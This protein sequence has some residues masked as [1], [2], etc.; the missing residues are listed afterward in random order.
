MSAIPGNGALDEVKTLMSQMDGARVLIAD[1]ERYIRAFLKILISKMKC[2]VVGEAT[3]GHEAVRLFGETRPD[4]LLLDINMPFKTGEDA[5][6]EIMTRFPDAFVV[7][8]TSVIDMDSVRKCIR[9]GAAN[10]ILKDTPVKEMM[11]II[12]ETWGKRHS[13][14]RSV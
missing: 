8:L 12:N 14:D 13:D 1:D 10:Y 7:M 9:L 6:Q 5:L 2:E 3:N 11:K 4:L